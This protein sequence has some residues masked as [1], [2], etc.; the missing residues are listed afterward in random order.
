MCQVILV[1]HTAPVRYIPRRGSRPREE[2]V[3][4]AT[5]VSLRETDL[6]ALGEPAFH[7][8]RPAVGRA[9]AYHA[10]QGGYWHDLTGPHGATPMTAEVFAAHL[11]GRLADIYAHE[12]Q[13]VEPFRGTPVPAE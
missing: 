11:E 2:W 4:L 7:I 12:W 5:P 10:F 8:A 1:R 3:A 13:I 9:V 6:R